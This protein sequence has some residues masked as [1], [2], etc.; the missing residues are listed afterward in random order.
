MSSGAASQ[1]VEHRLPRGYVALAL[2]TPTLPPADRTTCYVVGHHDAL[3]VDPGSRHRA[4][5]DRL[6]RVLWRLRGLGGRVAGVLVTH[7]HAD[8]TGGAATIA[9]EQDAPLL[10][11]PE[12]LARVACPGLRRRA[13]DEGER[14]FPDPGLELRCL[15]TPGHAPGHL[16]LF[17]ARRRVLIAGDMVPGVGTTLVAPPEGE[18]ALYLASLERLAAL[19]PALLLPAHGPALAD[20]EPAVRR[21]IAH[22]LWREQ[23]LLESL[24]SGGRDLWALTLAA[25]DDVPPWML[26]LASRSALA[27]LIKLEREGRIVRDGGS[28]RPAAS[29]R[30]GSVTA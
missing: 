25:Y 23:R 10:G 28:Y 9:R 1:I 12:T 30:A 18:M 13:V 7:H 21:L 8:H 24:G 27:H 22:R 20:A 16:C 29:R 26:G 15:H 11:H 5:L 2:R 14:L 4:E 3:V 6:R 19:R 17:E